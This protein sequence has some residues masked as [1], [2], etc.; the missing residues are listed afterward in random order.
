MGKVYITGDKH[1]SFNSFFRLNEQKVFSSDD[2]LIICGDASYVWNEDYPVR[3]ATLHQL[4]PG[5]AAFIDG[6][7]ENFDILDRLPIEEWNGGKVHRVGIRTV[8]LMRGE[9]YDILGDRYFCFGGARYSAILDQGRK[10]IDWWDQEDPTEEELTY[11]KT[12]LMNALSSINYV[13]SHE[14]PAFARQYT[15]RNKPM[16]ENYPLPYALEEWYYTIEK[17]PQFKK[18]YFGHMHEDII[19]SDKLRGIYNHFV[20]SGTENRL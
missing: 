8:H 4:F 15:K 9:I 17:E 5:T 20:E 3:I 7:H 16:P 12:A 11:G 18:W 19:I 1:G 2:I 10:G 14:P 6:N 13:I